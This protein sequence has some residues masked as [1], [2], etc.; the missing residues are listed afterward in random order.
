V[1]RNM[2]EFKHIKPFD[3]SYMDNPGPIV[4]F[5][6]PGMIHAGLS[7]QIFKKWAPCEN[8]MVIMP[9][10]C[11]AGTVGSKILNGAKRVEIEGR[12]VVDVKMSVQYMS[13][14]AHADAKGIMQLIR[15]CE[16]KNV[17][18]VHGEDGKM[19]FLRQK[20]MQEFGV[21]CYKPA[22]GETVEIPIKP[23]ISLDVSL[24]LLKK[25]VSSLGPTN[26][27]GLLVF[28]ENTLRLLDPESAM[29]E[30]GITCHQIRFTSTVTLLDHGPSSQTANRIYNT[31]RSNLK[32]Y[33]VQLLT[34]GSIS[35]DSVL[36]KVSGADDDD[37]KSVLV[38]WGYQDEKLGSYM[39]SVIEGL[40]RN[41]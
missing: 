9:G 25:N 33:T 36:I 27:H 12:Q 15:H 17:L 32:D 20:I 34:D 26:I 4:V 19:D 28:K 40:T 31:V 35:V 10:Y 8:N 41:Y 24:K 11:V 21:Q 5:A 39:F 14:S 3:K 37:E 18:L 16:P 1:H 6:T 22:N 7:L 13:F 29:N 23:K 38:S 2:F 30:L